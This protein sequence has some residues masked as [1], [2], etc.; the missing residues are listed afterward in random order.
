MTARNGM[1][2]RVSVIL[3]WTK[4]K[5]INLA[6]HGHAIKF[7]GLCLS[8]TLLLRHQVEFLNEDTVLILSDLQ[9][10]NCPFC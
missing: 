1:S 5:K 8:M 9:L 6:S 7:S 4:E 3:R 10:Y 2:M